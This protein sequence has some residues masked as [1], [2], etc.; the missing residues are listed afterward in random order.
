MPDQ[1]DALY[2]SLSGRPWPEAILD[3]VAQL[4]AV[5]SA[6]PQ[7][8]QRARMLTRGWGFWGYSSMPEKFDAPVAPVRLARHLTGR[9]EFPHL[10]DGDF[11]DPAV[12]RGLIAAV[13]Q[14]LGVGFV[15][16]GSQ[17]VW[18]DRLNRR[19]RRDVECRYPRRQ[20]NRVARMVL[21]L[22]EETAGYE[23]QLLLF[24][25]GRVAKTVFATRLSREEFR[26][27]E[28]TAGL[29]AYMTAN[30]GR[31]SLFAAGKQARAYDTVADQLHEALRR[32]EG[33]NW[34]ALAHVHPAPEVLEH[35]E[36]E[37]LAL[38][39]G[40]ALETMR[41]SGLELRRVVRETDPDLVRMVVRRGQDSST[42]NACAGA[43]NKARQVWLACVTALGRQDA[44][45][46]FMP[47]K[48]MRLMAADVASWHR[49]SGG[50]VD[51]DTRV[52][53]RLPKPWEV[54][55]G[56][57]TC[58]RDTVEAVCREEGVDPFATGWSRPRALTA[59]ESWRPT[60]ETVHGVAVADPLLAGWLR[61]IGVFS[62]KHIR[63]AQAR[64]FEQRFGEQAA[65]VERRQLAAHGDERGLYA[66]GADW[67]LP[68]GPPRE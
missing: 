29:V 27:D 28:L 65:W 56:A 37:R 52:W 33:A 61:R 47:G 45:D 63:P 49:A 46:A 1:L 43:W 12:L 34:F 3:S 9:A 53:A 25:A 7:L 19:Q 14:E 17:A 35:I 58:T 67:A 26:R 6:V 64:A 54:L 30:L 11:A 31:R 15:S 23:R 44:L 32:H 41:V 5:Q 36:P 18:S 57:A 4:P 40:H 51:P 13:R 50:D 60:P 10:T 38:L 16:A 48:V 2:E 39:L 22:E 68:G 62:G 42:W 20:Y 59:V 24:Q 21:I 8:G 66:V 55:F